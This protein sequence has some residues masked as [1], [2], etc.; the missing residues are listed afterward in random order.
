VTPTLEIVDL[1]L[2]GKL[3]ALL[4]VF[5]SALA[6][7]LPGDHHATRSFAAHVAGG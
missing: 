4:P 6:V 7:P 2:A 5:A 1:P 3:I